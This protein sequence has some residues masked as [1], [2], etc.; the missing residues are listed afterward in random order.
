MQEQQDWLNSQ[1]ITPVQDRKTDEDFWR[2]KNLYTEEDVVRLLYF[3]RLQ[4]KAEKD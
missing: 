2:T 3:Y 1:E 4:I